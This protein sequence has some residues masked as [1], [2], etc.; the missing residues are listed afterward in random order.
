[1]GLGLVRYIGLQQHVGALLLLAGYLCEAQFD[2]GQLTD[3]SV[4]QHGDVMPFSSSVVERMFGKRFPI[5]L[6]ATTV[7]MIKCMMY[8]TSVNH[9]RIPKNSFHCL[10]KFVTGALQ[11]C[12]FCNGR[13]REKT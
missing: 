3:S 7:V 11:R 12:F 1:M 8:G 9:M 13:C 2:W 5:P 6:L 10:R 4:P